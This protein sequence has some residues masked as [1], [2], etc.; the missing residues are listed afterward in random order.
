MQ[1]QPKES[2]QPMEKVPPNSELVPRF[3]PQVT[4][5]TN[6]EELS[7]KSKSSCPEL[8]LVVFNP[9]LARFLKAMEEVAASSAKRPKGLNLNSEN[10]DTEFCIAF[11]KSVL[12]SFLETME[13]EPVYSEV[14]SCFQ[15]EV[16]SS[17]RPT[18]LSSKVRNQGP[19]Y[20]R[21]SSQS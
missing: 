10:L 13:E 20:L 16:P 8:R 15:P 2:F 18:G 11:F 21:S 14:I 12:A 3:Q 4:S 5:S 19:K 1:D 7:L 17:K 6:L 9:S